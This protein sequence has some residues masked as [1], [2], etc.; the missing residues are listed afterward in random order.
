MALI[1]NVYLYKNSLN[2]PQTDKDCQ[3]RN[4]V[5]PK[6]DRTLSVKTNQHH[7][8]AAKAIGQCTYKTLHIILYVSLDKG[9]LA[10]LRHS[11]ITEKVY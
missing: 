9:T 4:K 5:D 1:T 10:P 8:L 7:A 11:I 2:K 6:S 3:T